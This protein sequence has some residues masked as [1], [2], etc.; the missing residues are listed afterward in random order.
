MRLRTDLLPHGSYPDV[1]L[2]I[3]VLRATTTAVTYL[4][5]GAEALAGV[6]S[7]AHTL[8]QMIWRLETQ[9]RRFDTPEARAALASRLRNVTRLASDP[10]LRRSLWDQFRAL[11]LDR[12]CKAMRHPVVV[13]LRNVYKPDDMARQGFRYHGVGRGQ[14]AAQG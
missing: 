13:D 9:G 10:D 2:V 12:V 5:H 4:E 6:L 3:D 8:S 1:V 14:E 7:K 11:D